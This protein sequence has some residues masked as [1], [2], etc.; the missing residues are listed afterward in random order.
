[1]NAFEKYVANEMLAQADRLIG[2]EYGEEAD[3]IFGNDLEA[4]AYVCGKPSCMYF[5]N[6]Y[7]DGLRKA[8]KKYNITTSYAE[9]PEL[10]IIECIY[11]TAFDI[12]DRMST[13]AFRGER[14]QTD[15]DIEF[16][17]ECLKKYM[18]EN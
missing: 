1:M 7:I 18:E 3:R 2:C 8:V 9:N 10:F 11:N 17:V 13:A 15:A 14:Y 4:G 12:V 5:V 6:V 16:F